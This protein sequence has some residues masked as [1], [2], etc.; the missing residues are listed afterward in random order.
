MKEKY[1][2]NARII[3][4]KNDL[5]EIGG[6]IIDSK[7]FIKAAGKKVVNGNLPSSADKI[8]LNKQIL[9]PGIVD[10]RVFVGEPGYEYKENFRTLSNAALSGGVT[11]VVSMPNTS[12]TIDNVS[13]VDFLKR[14]GRDKSKI[15]IFPAA[16]LTKNAE[17][18]QMTE[19]GLLKRKGII[20]FTD[21]VKTVQ[22]PQVMTR[23]MNLASQ[24]ESLIMQHAEDN[25]LSQDGLI[26]E[27]EI[28][29]RLGLK[30][31]PF[32]AEKIIVERDLSFL[33]E[34]FCRYH[35]SQ[36]SS[37]KTISVIKKAKK[38]GKIFTTG[39]SV[40]NLSLNEN[41][42]G[43]FKTFLKLSPPLRTEN[44]RLALVESVSD[45][46]ID[47]IVSDHKPQDEESKRLTFAQAATGAT[48]VETLLPLALELFHN[49][50]IKLKQL[51]AAITSNPSKILGINKGSL[52]KGNDAD[53]CVIDINKPW[54][55]DKDKL[56]SK[57][58][59]TPIENR[60]LQ[61]QVLKTFVKGEL[62]YKNI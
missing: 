8:D 16:T 59:N 3:D 42:I 46:T 34:Y 61:G 60:K 27:G 5:D 45:G 2:T 7:G 57:S 28:S 52:D 21:G 23:I 49:K 33:E 53:L 4:P 20:A 10:M 14:R 24:S 17:G 13:M 25:I 15:N 30:G 44:D 9:M 19:F 39:V 6:L 22:D 43:D 12:P 55:V 31:I 36:I 62:A 40:N 47:V 50:S 41:D 26:N 32:L 35:I 1:L 56:K 11:S 29:T 38:E 51:I 54:I 48:G 37:E 58:K 18:K